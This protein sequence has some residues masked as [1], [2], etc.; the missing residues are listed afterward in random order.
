MTIQIPSEFEGFASV[1]VPVAGRVAYGLGRNASYAAA[2]R[3]DLPTIRLGKKIRV[4]VAQLLK[5]LGYEL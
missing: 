5:Q 2:A 4:P 3:G 1:D